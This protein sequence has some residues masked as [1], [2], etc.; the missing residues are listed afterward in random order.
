MEADWVDVATD[1]VWRR[2][3]LYMVEIGEVVKV[4]AVR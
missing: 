3:A 4:S 2:S 1:E